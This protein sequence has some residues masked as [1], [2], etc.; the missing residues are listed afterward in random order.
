MA[1]SATRGVSLEGA[2]LC[3][4]DGAVLPR[5]LRCAA[6]GSCSVG[7]PGAA[8]GIYVANKA[9]RHHV[10]CGIGPG[11]DRAAV[12]DGVEDREGEHH[13]LLPAADGE[14]AQTGRA[15]QDPLNGE[16]CPGTPPP[17]LSHTYSLCVQ[18]IHGA[19]LPF[20]TPPPSDF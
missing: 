17:H 5:S 11:L 14:R 3:A 6:A 8:A 19:N 16:H 7:V 4:S 13:E 10:G 12:G 20:P 9:Q 2:D 18:S 15:L 1:L